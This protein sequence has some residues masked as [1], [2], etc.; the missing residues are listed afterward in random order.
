MA[1]GEALNRKQ[2]SSLSFIALLLI[3]VGGAYFGYVY[4]ASKPPTGGGGTSLVTAVAENDQFPF[5]PIAGITVTATTQGH[6]PVSGTTT[7]SWSTEPKLPM[8][9]ATNYTITAHRNSQDLTV[10]LITPAFNG[11]G[12]FVLYVLVNYLGTIDSISFSPP[13]GPYQLWP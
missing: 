8:Y 6:N 1:E 11:T 9:P 10:T 3:I 7:T 12:P 5:T 4:F 2:R 13:I